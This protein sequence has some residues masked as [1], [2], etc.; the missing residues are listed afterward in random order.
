MR[1]RRR[2]RRPPQRGNLLDNPVEDDVPITCGLSLLN[3][4][5]PWRGRCQTR[6]YKTRSKTYRAR[7]QGSAASIC[8]ICQLPFCAATKVNRRV[9]EPATVAGAATGS[10]VPCASRRRGCAGYAARCAGLPTGSRAIP[11]FSVR[12]GLSAP[13]PSPEP[14]PRPRFARHATDEKWCYTR[15]V[16]CNTRVGAAAAPASDNLWMLG[17]LPRQR[18]AQEPRTSAERRYVSTLAAPHATRQIPYMAIPLHLTRPLGARLDRCSPCG[19]RP[20]CDRRHVRPAAGWRGGMNRPRRDA[21]CPNGEA[22]AP[23]PAGRGILHPV[24]GVR[25]VEGV[26]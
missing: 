19:A 21:R 25:C 15:H 14:L 5:P 1:G 9:S 17:R 13:R 18:P 6:C 16:H 20:P 12:S 8:T 22:C 10:L 2:R 23:V 3:S 24:I 4:T 11:C 7:L 26:T